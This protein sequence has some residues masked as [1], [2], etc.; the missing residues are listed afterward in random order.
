D[1]GRLTE[2]RGVEVWKGDLAV[3]ASARNAEVTTAFPVDQAIG[4]LKA[5]VYVMV[6]QPQEMKNVDTNSDS[7]ATQWLIVSDLGLA[8]FSGNGGIHA[9]VNS[10]ASTDAKSGVEVRLLSRGNEILATRKTDASGH[11]Q[12]EP[13]LT[14]GEGAAAPALLAAAD[15]Q[16]DF[17]F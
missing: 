4:D 2:S 14:A 13:G 8:A 9:F 12:F 16:G 6:A 11:A 15:A 17:A 5:G 3:N 1:V 10:L 7:L